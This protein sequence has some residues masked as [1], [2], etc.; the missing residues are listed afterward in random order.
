MFTCIFVEPFIKERLIEPKHSEEGSEDEPEVPLERLGLIEV[1]GVERDLVETDF[2]NS[3]TLLR[4]AS[5]LD[6]LSK[7]EHGIRVVDSDDD[8]KVALFEF[9]FVWW[10]WYS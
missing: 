2:S 8:D 9:G 3:R 6:G 7:G 4:G 1:G 5:W 10:L